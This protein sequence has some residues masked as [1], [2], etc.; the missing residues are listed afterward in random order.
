[1]HLSRPDL[2]DK[3]NRY[4]FT[5]PWDSAYGQTYTEVWAPDANEARELMFGTVSNK[6]SFIYEEGAFAAQIK[7][8]NLECLS[9]IKPTDTG[10]YRIAFVTPHFEE[11]ESNNAA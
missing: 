3:L 2:K 4:Y 11:E 5:Y 1:M 8:Y 9:V 7:G 6:W 10:L